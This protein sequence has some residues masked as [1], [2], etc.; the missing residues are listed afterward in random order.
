MNQYRMFFVQTSTL[1]TPR[2]HNFFTENGTCCMQIN[3]L[4]IKSPVELQD[5][6]NNLRKFANLVQ[7]AFV[8]MGL[9]RYLVVMMN[10]LEHLDL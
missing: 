6:F 7:I 1:P 2:M 4:P 8:I 9:L 10:S 5:N 3:Q